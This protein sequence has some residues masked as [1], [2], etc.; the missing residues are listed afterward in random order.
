[1][2]QAE[3]PNIS[4]VYE[5]ANFTDYWPLLN[6]K[7]AGGQL[8][9]VMQHDYAFL[10]EW[11]SR[12]L[13]M[14]LDPFFEDGTIDVSNV[15]DVY[16]AGGRI[17]DET[18]GLSLGTNSPSMIIDVDAFEAAGMELPPTDWTW[19]DF[20][21]IATQLHDELG[22]WAISYGMPD[23][24]FWRGLYISEGGWIINE[25]GTALGYSD[26]Q[27]LIDYFNMLLRLQEAG[28]IATP[29]E[30]T[31]ASANGHENSPIVT[32]GEAM[33]YQWSNQVVSIFSAAGEERNLRLWPLPRNEGGV[34]QN[35]LK[36]SMF[37]SITSQCDNPQAAAEFINYFTNSP[38]A[39]EVLFAERG[40]PISSEIREHLLPML[41]KAGSET[42]TFISQIAE[43]ASPVP[44]PEPPG[45]TDVLNNVYGPL[46]SEPVLYGQIPVEEGVAI[47]RSEA[48]A[49]LAQNAE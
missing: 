3:N 16:L 37:F 6:T 14:P 10:S 4:F 15:D 44:P 26:D 20:E 8:P 12:G 25:D 32:G 33:R 9:C 39:N 13:L 17:G 28:V 11:A 46:F 21:E 35:Y 43:D 1:M 30:A 2:Y 49:I 7:A 41:D 34:S 23:P 47:L 38:E 36:P 31:E 19:A 48:D 29:E 18:Y 27:P 22:I 45:W 24:Q 40:V 42:F 5:F